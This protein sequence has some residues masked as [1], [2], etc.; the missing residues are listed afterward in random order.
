MFSMLRPCSGSS[1]LPLLIPTTWPWELISGPPLLPGFMAASV[2]NTSSAA[3]E[4]MPLVTVIAPLIP[5]GNPKANTSSPTLTWSESAI[6][7]EVNDLLPSIEITAKSTKRFL[8]ITFPCKCEPLYKVTI[9]LSLPLT[10]CALVTTQP[11]SQKRNQIH[12]WKSPQRKV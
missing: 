11:C 10:T 2:W 1:S 4:T 6:C 7:S 8:P 9:T 5:P 12:A 3:A